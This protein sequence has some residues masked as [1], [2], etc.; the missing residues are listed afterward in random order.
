VGEHS[1]GLVS[2]CLSSSSLQGCFLVFLAGRGVISD[3]EGACNCGVVEDGGEGAPCGAAEDG[4]RN[5]A[6]GGGGM[7]PATEVVVGSD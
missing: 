5:P 6:S 7:G 1:W 2:S 3:E 4:G